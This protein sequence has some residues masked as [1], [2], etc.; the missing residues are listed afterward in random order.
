M[1]IFENKN[2]LEMKKLLFFLILNPLFLFAQTSKF[3]HVDQFGYKPNH[4]KVAVISNPQIGFNATDSYTPSTI[5]EVRNA[6]NNTIV[7]SGN[8]TVWNN[9]STHNQS[10]DKGWWFDFSSVTQNGDYYIY[11]VAKNERSDTF[12]IADNVYNE[13]LK[14]ATKSFY[15]NRCGIAKVTPYTLNGYIDATSFSQDT[16]AR[17]VHQQNNASTA[18]DMSGGWFDAGDYNKYVTFAESPI[19]DLLW[20]YTNNPS[21]FGDNWNIPES[22]NNIPD[23][24]DEIKWELDWLLKMINTDGSVHIKIGAR[25]YNENSSSPPSV[26]TAIR[27]YEKTCTS[28]A[29]AASTMLAHAAKVFSTISSMNSYSQILKDKALLTWNYVEPRIE[30]ATLDENCDDLSVVSGDAD[31]TFDQQ[32]KMALNAA[33]YLF[34]ITAD[35]RFQQYIGNHLNDINLSEIWNNYDIMSVDALLHFTTISGVSLPLKNRILDA[36]IATA[37]SNDNNYFEFS[38]LDL[39]RAY[40]NDWTYHWGSN[41]QKSNFG[42]LNFILD[43]YDINTNSNSSYILRA[44]EHIHYFHG[45]NPLGLVYLSNM[46]SIGAEKSANQIYHAWFAD[47]SIWDDTET[48]TFGP[49]PGYVTGGANANYNADTSLSPP[50]NQ[51]MQK[52]YLNF[53]SIAGNSWEITEPSITNQAAY[54]RLLAQLINLDQ[55]TLAV[56]DFN[57]QKTFYTLIPNPT[58]NFLKIASHETDSITV[59]V[60]NLQ[61]QLVK[62][63]FETT[64]NENININDLDS[65]MY[66]IKIKNDYKMTTLKFIKN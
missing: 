33:I 22:G 54:V 4:T 52:S 13:V 28:S 17:D 43:E 45:V 34:D 8:P 60:Y 9:G 18:K 14:T 49:A 35:D 11:D 10:G 12:T 62:K 6:N 53:N 55:G 30:N 40:A 65:G 47:G 5:L 24:I 48:S 29:I 42:N 37:T 59:S 44:K 56:N 64:T 61:G 3:I 39:Y 46:V 7:F 41:I 15:Y 26:N 20:A 25:N 32:R 63:S 19:H 66:L 27:Y 51:P 23:L 16:Q 31:R 57:H 36:A 50:Y 58:S 1:F 2:I 38:N 21:I